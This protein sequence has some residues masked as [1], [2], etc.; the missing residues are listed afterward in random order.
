M[1]HLLYYLLSRENSKR[2]RDMLPGTPVL[3]VSGREE[4]KHPLI[5]IYSGNYYSLGHSDELMHNFLVA[6]E[7]AFFLH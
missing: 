6:S 3:A 4:C 7:A 5:F 2:L 1:E